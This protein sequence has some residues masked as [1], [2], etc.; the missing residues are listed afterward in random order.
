MY[1]IAYGSN[2]SLRMMRKRCPNAGIVGKTLL[3][4]FTL[5]FRG[6]IENNGYLTVEEEHYGTVPV[7]IFEVDGDD[8]R[9][10]DICE[11][12]PILYD[13][14]TISISYNGSQIEAFIYV[15]NDEFGYQLPSAKY[16]KTCLI[17][18]HDFGFSN[19]YL[20]RALNRTRENKKRFR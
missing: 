15:M 5:A 4:G 2:L 18:Y 14:R 20:I 3:N 12:Y 13:K 10:L 17:G 7:A 9:S 6:D 11:G 19:E 1:Y 8:L 16:F